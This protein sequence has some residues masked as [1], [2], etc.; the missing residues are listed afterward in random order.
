[1]S[2]KIHDN[3]LLGLRNYFNDKLIELYPE[4]ELSSLFFIGLDF[5]LKLSRLQYMSDP[6]ATVSESDILRMR[7]LAKELKKERPIQHI[8]GE[9]EFM[10][11]KIKVNED[12]LIPRPETEEIVDDIF[13]K[14]KNIRTAVDLCTGSACIA[15]ALKNNYSDSIVLAL[16]KSRD[17]LKVAKENALLNNLDIEFKEEDIL[18]DELNLP[19]CDLIVSN[20][21]YVR[22]SEKKQMSKNVLEFEPEMA[23]FV[24][25]NDPL[26]FY[27]EIIRIAVEKLKPNAWLF[28]E[29]NEKFG[30]EILD[31]MNKAGISKNAYVNKDLNGKDRWVSGQKGE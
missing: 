19:D 10:D 15:L 29:I 7:Y 13:K 16:D 12:V 25:D 27:R 17:A 26:I 18:V 21:P 1:M 23:L 22:N 9:C 6:Q 14:V 20:P 5:Y 4:E 28:M 30:K 24:E 11:L 8:L 2:I 3:S 31:M